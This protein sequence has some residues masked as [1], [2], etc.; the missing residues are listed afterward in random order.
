MQAELQLLKK[1]LETYSKEGTKE[2]QE[3]AIKAIDICIGQQEN[4]IG[5]EQGKETLE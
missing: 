4:I 2:A 5:L 1:A 3:A